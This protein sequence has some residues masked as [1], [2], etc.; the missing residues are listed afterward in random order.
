MEKITI[1]N[2]KILILFL[3]LFNSNTNAGVNNF[4]HSEKKIEQ[5]SVIE[6]FVNI[7]GT[8]IL[9]TREITYTN[10]E[11]A[12]IGINP[13]NLESILIKDTNFI[14]TEKIYFEN[15]PFIK[16]KRKFYNESNTI[17]EVNKKD[18][19]FQDNA[20]VLLTTDLCPVEKSLDTNFYIAISELE[21]K[22]SNKIPFFIFF[23]GRWIETHHSELEWIKSRGFSFIACNHTYNHK[24]IKENFSNSV[25][26]DEIIKT[27]LIMLNNGIIPSCFFRFPGLKY[28]KENLSVLY[29][30]NLIPLSVNF[31]GGQKSFPKKSI[32]LVHSNG[33]VPIE[34]K[35]FIQ[36]LKGIKNKNIKFVT[37]GE[38][39]KS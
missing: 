23:S 39:F 25:L 7:N 24:I 8:N 14:D 3:I 5:Y 11:K 29:E 9:L 20:I 21:Q 17:G 27:E 13:E 2:K 31:W 15:T 34:V 37:P 32:L 30:M 22:I 16:I 10:K 33:S 19:L 28:N 4:F 35:K 36:F 6:R 18:S 12:F 38:W 26:K 1:K